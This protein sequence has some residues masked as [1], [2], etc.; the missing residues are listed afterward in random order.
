MWY[1]LLMPAELPQ[2]EIDAA[3]AAVAFAKQVR[4]MNAKRTS[5]GSQ[6]RARELEVAQTRIREAMVPIKSAIG[7]F[8][9]GPQTPVAEA[10]R[11]RI[12]EVSAALQSERRKLWKMAKVTKPVEA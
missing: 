11:Q 1:D 12:R 4:K 5:T 3:E 2:A 10:N 7:K 8:Q 6:Q 9:Y